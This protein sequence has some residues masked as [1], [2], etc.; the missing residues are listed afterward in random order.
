[1][2]EKCKKNKTNMGMKMSQKCFSFHSY[3][4]WIETPQTCRLILS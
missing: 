1:M 2:E 3:G 4:Y